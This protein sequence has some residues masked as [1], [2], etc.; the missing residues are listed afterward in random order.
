M[1]RNKTGYIT[2]ICKS[3]LKVLYCLYQS[4]NIYKKKISSTVRTNKIVLKSIIII[5]YLTKKCPDV[6]AH[7]SN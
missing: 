3:V 1:H 4:L 2:V 5:E 6:P 7:P